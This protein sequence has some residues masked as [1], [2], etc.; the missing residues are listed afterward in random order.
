MCDKKKCS[1]SCK[2][3]KCSNRGNCVMCKRS[4]EHIKN[5]STYTLEEKRSILNAIRNG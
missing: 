3:K 4:E 2:N 5:W 1:S